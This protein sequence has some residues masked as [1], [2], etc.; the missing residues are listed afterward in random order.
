MEIEEQAAAEPELVQGDVEQEQQDA[1]VQTDAPA[2]ETA[3][4]PQELVVSFG[5]EESPT[6]EDESAPEWVRKVRTENREK[7]KRI[8][9]L[10][11]KLKAAE[12]PA[13]AA[14]VVG[15][16]PTLES[17]EYDEAKFETSLDAW[18][19]QK[20]TVE[21]VEQAKRDEQ[22]K[23]QE[24][25]A[26]K[27]NGYQES[28]KVLG[29][30]DFAEAEDEAKAKLSV[31]QQSILVSGCKAPAMFV[32]ALGKNPAKLAELSA[33]TDPVEFAFAAARLENAVTTKPRTRPQ[34]EGKV[35]GSAPSSGIGDKTLD[36]LEAEADRTGDRSK[37]I[38]YKREL[39]QKG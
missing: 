16:K 17:C 1:Q 10:E 18:K 27:L 9:E 8:R 11:E 35:T 5:D 24:A 15:P 30:Q 7:T 12:Q 14:V 13:Q 6:S 34:P 37:V 33:I 20:R 23:S 36:R 21:A 25:W 19:E 38:A 28:S 2:A 39:K 4:E 3:D 32:Y 22:A 29:V 26:K 31:M